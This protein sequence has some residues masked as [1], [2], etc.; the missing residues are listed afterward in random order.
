VCYPVEVG[1]DP[2]L[3]SGISKNRNLRII[4]GYF[5]SWRYGVHS[6]S[7]LRDLFDQIV[8]TNEYLLSLESRFRSSEVVV[9]HIRLGDYRL[10][11]NA[12][13][14]ILSTNYYELCLNYMEKN[15]IEKDIYVFSDEIDLA[16]SIFSEVFPEKT[17]W[18]K[19]VGEHDPTE[20]LKVMSLAA[21]FII[22]NS[23]FSWWAAY[24]SE[25]SE[26]VLAPTKW[27]KSAKDPN[28]LIPPSWNRIE[29]DWNEIEQ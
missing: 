10:E 8:I 12:Y 4:N 13:I 29:S 17:N 6:R 22:G 28:D 14:G 15:N 11:S 2:E 7:I 21:G 3:L 19:P 26:F 18:V 16:K 23:S 5:Q 1:F 27:F 25:N 20:V 24:M 9:V